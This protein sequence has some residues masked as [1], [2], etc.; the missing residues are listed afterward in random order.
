MTEDQYREWFEKKLAQNRNAK[1]KPATVSAKFAKQFG[2]RGYYAD[3]TISA[4]EAEAF[5]FVSKV[6]WENF[7]NYDEAV[8]DGILIIL[9]S[10]K[11]IPILSGA[12]T[13]EKVHWNEVDSCY[14]AF[15]QA[16]KLATQEIL[17]QSGYWG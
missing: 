17:R 1:L 3:V 7:D 14:E 16:A 10:Q 2:A 9:F 11:S 12:F 6:K 13:L 5:S 4:Q 15:F 8:I